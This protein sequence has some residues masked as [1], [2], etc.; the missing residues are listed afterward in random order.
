MAG[1]HRIRCGR[2]TGKVCNR[3]RD[4]AQ[5]VGVEIEDRQVSHLYYITRK[6]LEGKTVGG[7]HKR[8]WQAQAPGCNTRTHTHTH[9]RTQA[10]KHTT[11]FCTS[12][13]QAGMTVNLLNR[14]LSSRNAVQRANESGRAAQD[15]MAW[16]GLG[17]SRIHRYHSAEPGNFTRYPQCKRAHKHPLPL[18]VILLQREQ[19]QPH[20]PKSALSAANQHHDR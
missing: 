3:G 19:Q 5:L 4:R 15:G 8:L 2:R 13:I 11:V 10:H 16:Y 9:A 20:A 1:Q 6:K 17:W 14:S 18:Y 7:G 12:G